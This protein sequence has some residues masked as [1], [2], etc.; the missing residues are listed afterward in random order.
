MS[1]LV[2][3]FGSLGLLLAAYW[4]YGR[5][6]SRS[7]F[8]LS[9]T[10]QVPSRAL[11]DDQDYVPSPKSVVF[12]HHF[13]SIAGTGPIVGPALAVFWGW[14]P[15][16]AWILLGGILIGGV[17][18]LSA[19]VISLR[20]RGY[21]IGEIAGRM[22]SKRARILFLSILALALWIVL[23]IFGL[24]IAQIFSLYPQSVL[25]VWL[26]MPLAMCVGL[27]THRW[28]VSMLI[29]GLVSLSLLYFA[30]YLG[31]Y[32]L[33]I[34]ITTGQPDGYLNP[35]VIWTICLLVYCYFAST[36]P[37]WLLLQPRDLVNSHQL[38]VG[39][40]VLL[41]GLL[42]ASVSGQCDLFASADA[43]SDS[44]PVDAPPMLPFLFI[45]I[46]CGACSGF[47]CLVSSG[48]SSK[49]IGNERDA[50]LV[51]YGAML[52]ESALAV[53]VVLACTAGIGMGV[54]Q[55]QSPAVTQSSTQSAEAGNAAIAA[56]SVV[57]SAKSDSG[58]QS[59]SLLG[60]GSPTGYV[61]VTDAAGQPITGRAAW[62]QYYR[63]SAEGTGWKATGSLPVVLRAFVE[64]SANL[65][66]TV[67]LPIELCIG[68]MAVLVAGF[69]ATTLDT[70][71]RLQR[72]VIQELG[73]SLGLPTHN[74]HV[75]TAAAV[76]VAGAIA[77]FAGDKPGSGGSILWPLF[78]ATNQL[79][80]GL[81]LMVGTFYL[82]RRNK[83]IALLAIPALLMMLIPGWA[84][85]Y[86]LVYDW[87]PQRNWILIAFGS[88]ILALQ[89]WMF[90]EGVLM[91]RR[92]RGVLEPQLEPLPGLR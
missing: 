84:M 89:M 29:P 34:Q 78:G 15:A 70:A 57:S 38:F 82:W 37:V 47:H 31:V 23:A 51:G 43:V 18:D 8:E 21:T 77:I 88:S 60:I 13:T 45:T 14:L 53:V 35:V 49:Q 26:A 63:V 54:L 62:D 66:A 2:V 75:A 12:G 79:L 50:Q 72:Y 36:L 28:G 27:V 90:L 44:V 76:G 33:P 40:A 25:S 46:A 87:I 19:L 11:Q 55:R 48:T 83:Q 74:K 32:H 10:A 81:A 85:T 64:G 1:T 52:F 20:N 41:A 4:T 22:I 67:G 92:A 68:I 30:V 73:G 61:R 91:W 58:A 39:L 86:S 3:C 71:T 56:A 9:S 65:M 5:W 16:L 17:H 7:L 42:I 24:V 80:A 69:A 59:G 6:L